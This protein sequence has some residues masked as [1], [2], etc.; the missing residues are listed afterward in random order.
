MS[1]TEMK[2]DPARAK[3]LISQLQEVQQRITAV[4]KGRPVS[5]TLVYMLMASFPR[6]PATL[7]Q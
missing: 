2:I 3:A 7:I 4:A 6:N 5:N 1:E